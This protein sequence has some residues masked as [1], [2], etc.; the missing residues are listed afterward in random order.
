MPKKSWLRVLKTVD[1]MMPLYG[2]TLK[3]LMATRGV[4]KWI[5][6]LADTHVSRGQSQDGNSEQKT[7]DI[8][9]RTFPT[10]PETSSQNGASLKTSATTSIW[11]SEKSNRNWKAWTTKLRQDSLQRRKLAQRISE[12]DYLSWRTPDASMGNRGA[13]SQASFK[14]SLKNGTHAINLNDQVMWSTPLS[15]DWKGLHG[16]NSYQS[17]SGIVFDSLE[18][19]RHRQNHQNGNQSSESHQDFRPRLNPNFAEWLMGWM[20]GWTY[21]HSPIPETGYTPSEME[22]YLYSLRSRLEFLW[23]NYQNVNNSIPEQTELA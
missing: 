23:T 12:N 13:K 21:P 4:E 22:S 1:W 18:F 11:D 19:F 9:S 20:P 15:R 2:L 17:K 8:Y 7:Q 10:S 14:D 16:E 5:A 3:P 6:S